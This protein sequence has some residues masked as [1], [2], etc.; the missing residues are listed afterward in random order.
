MVGV[1]NKL[2]DE[3]VEAGTIPLF[4][5]QTGTWIGQVWGDMDQAR[6]SGTS[7]AGTLL[8]SVG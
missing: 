4:K 2:P 3:V 5:K 6:A 7:V 8:A 1:C